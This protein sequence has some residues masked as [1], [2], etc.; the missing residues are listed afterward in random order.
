MSVDKCLIAIATAASIVTSSGC[1]GFQ[2][3]VD[4]VVS[5]DGRPLPAAHVVFHPDVPGPIAYGLSLDDGSYWLK[6]GATKRG[7]QPGTY[8]VTVTATKEADVDK[9][10][11]KEIPLSTPPVYADS[12]KTPLRC[13][14]A[15][16][17]NKIPL[18]LE[19]AGP[20]AVGTPPRDR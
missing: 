14:V 16:G 6:T 20:M 3:S 7:L 15:K 11:E 9:A 5:L 2:A 1:G 10:E 13:T 18:A 12:V 17:H 8:R 4:G 19:S